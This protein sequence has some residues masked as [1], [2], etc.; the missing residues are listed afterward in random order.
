[1]NDNIKQGFGQGTPTEQ[2]DDKKKPEVK[3]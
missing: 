2:S 3:D 1:M